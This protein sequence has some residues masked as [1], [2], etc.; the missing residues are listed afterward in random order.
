MTGKPRSKHQ[1]IKIDTLKFRTLR[2]HEEANLW[3]LREYS[4]KINVIF[5][6]LDPK[7]LY[8]E[9]HDAKIDI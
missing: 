8:L 2:S 5:E 1:S 7:N 9:T 4:P 6:I 3:P